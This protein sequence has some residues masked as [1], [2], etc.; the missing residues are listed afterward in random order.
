MSTHNSTS[1]SP[2]LTATVLA[3]SSLTVLANATIA[4]SLP[5]LSRAFDSTPGIETL[6]PLVV[7]LPSLAV[8]LTAALFGLAADRFDRRRV[9]ALAMITYA[10]GGASGAIAETMPQILAGRLLLGIGVAGTLTIATQLAAQFWHGADRARFM[11]WQGAAISACGIASLLV[12]G[13]L[14]EASWRAPFLVYLV[15]L[16][17]AA[18][19]WHVIP[20]RSSANVDEVVAV[21]ATPNARVEPFPLRIF[22]LTGGIM[23]LVMVFILLTAT[24]LPFLLQE[25]ALTSPGLIGLTLSMMTVAS[26]P[27]GFFYGRVRAVMGTRT[28]AI[29]ALGLMA[30]GYVVISQSHALAPVIIGVVVTGL[31]LGLIIPNQNVWLMAHV[32]EGV[33][34]RAAGWM[35]TALFAGQFVS[36]VISGALLGWMALHT[37]FVTFAGALLAAAFALLASAAVTKFSSSGDRA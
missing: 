30:L 10:L 15:A 22:A 14:A 32:R 35:T 36:P 4:P 34:G 20:H 13:V 31:G 19:A 37:V 1:A 26:F 21:E 6:A 25:I 16:P 28:I 18:L 33:R 9:L 17:V 23:F 7:S 29:V 5:G 12:G 8:V 24:R 27:T 3:V 2:V 11:G